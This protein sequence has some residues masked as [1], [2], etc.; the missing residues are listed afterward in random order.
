VVTVLT[1]ITA[2][3][4]GYAPSRRRFWGKAFF[5]AAFLDGIMIPPQALRAFPIRGGA[6]VRHDDRV[7]PGAPGR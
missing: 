7:Q 4:A 6:G 5:Y 1:V 2:S 3:M